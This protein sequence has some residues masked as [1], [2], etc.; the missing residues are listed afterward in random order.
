MCP[1]SNWKQ[2]NDRKEAERQR[3]GIHGLVNLFGPET[4]QF[5]VAC[6]AL[7]L[8]LLHPNLAILQKAKPR[9]AGRRAGIGR[10]LLPGVFQAGHLLAGAG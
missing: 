5:C 4:Y 10:R 1:S 6:G 9:Q 8:Y 2:R 7:V 3:A